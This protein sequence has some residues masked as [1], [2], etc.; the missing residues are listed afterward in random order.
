MFRTDDVYWASSQQKE[1]RIVCA[2][3]LRSRDNA[4]NIYV[5]SIYGKTK[6]KTYMFYILY[7]SSSLCLYAA[8]VNPISALFTNFKFPNSSQ[9]YD[10]LANSAFLCIRNNVEICAL[11]IYILYIVISTH[12]TI[13]LQHKLFPQLLFIAT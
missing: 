13:V 11:Y 6:G 1:K 12:Y 4:A 2:D 10:L 5:C 9:L 7:S 8:H 3:I